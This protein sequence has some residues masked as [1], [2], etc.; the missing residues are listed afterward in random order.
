M[1]DEEVDE[2]LKG[3]QIGAW[4]RLTS[5]S[6]VFSV[7]I[8]GWQRQ[9]RKLRANDTKPVKQRVL[10]LEPVYLKCTLLSTKLDY[11]EDG[12]YNSKM[13]RHGPR[14]RYEDLARW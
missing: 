2:L 12:T 6:N 9:L 4:V 8:Q 5:Y 14:L 1:T 13:E 11:H 3:V 7:F 10:F